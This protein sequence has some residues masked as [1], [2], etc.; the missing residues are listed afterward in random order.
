MDY[1]PDC[2][3]LNLFVNHLNNDLVRLYEAHVK[4]HN[5]K[6]S[7]DPFPDS[8]F[9]IFVP[10]VVQFNNSTVDSVMIDHQIKAEMYFLNSKLQAQSCA[11]LMY[12]RS[13]ISKTP[14]MLANHTGII[15][16]S[17]RGSLI[18]AFRYLK[19]ER[20]NFDKKLTKKEEGYVVDRHTRLLQICH[21]S[22]CP[23]HVRL[24]DEEQFTITQRDK[25]GFG[26][27]GLVGI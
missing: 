24:V 13:S 1:K 18:G 2:A 21:P 14:L 11:F 27:T 19:S 16:A 25:G 10:E 26:S 12:P 7:T 17:Y 23:V 20:I 8:G 4:K 15:D 6:I 5:D 3:I 22:L 9:D